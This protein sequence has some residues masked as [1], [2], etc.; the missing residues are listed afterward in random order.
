MKF[1]KG[2]MLTNLVNKI[3]KP[4]GVIINRCLYTPKPPKPYEYRYYL[5]KR[6]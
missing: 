6:K 4:F 1:I 2:H 3:L 5:E